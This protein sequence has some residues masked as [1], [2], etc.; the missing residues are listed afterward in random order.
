MNTSSFSESVVE[1]AALAWL[2]GQGY[3]VLHGPDIAAGEPFS[4]RSDP[5]YRDV[6][7]ERRLR[8][9]LVRLNPELPP[10]AV[11]DAYRK[12][13]RVDAPSLVERN[14]AAHRMLVEGVTVEYRRKGRPIAGAQAR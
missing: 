7:M 8:Q 3:A 11:E 1:D 4:E 5:N 13:T 9:A 2:E 12:L 6:L 10:E 14:R